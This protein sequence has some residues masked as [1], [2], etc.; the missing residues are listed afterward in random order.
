V[1]LDPFMRV[2]AH[3]PFQEAEPYAE[4]LGALL[5]SL[6]PSN[7]HAGRE[8][9]APVLVLPRVFEPEFCRTL[10][11][12]YEE[13]GGESSGFMR[14][15]EGKTIGILD[16]KFKRR[17]DFVFD[18]QDEFEALREA[19]RA[20]VSRRLI[21]AIYK[22]FQFK[23]SR[24]E[25]FIVACYDAEAGGFFRPHRDNTTLGTAHRQFAVTI[26]LNADEFEGGE[27][28]FPE[29]GPQSYRAPTGGAVVFSCGL[30]HEALPVT[31]GRRY[32][33]LPFL[34]N[35]EGAEIRRRNRHVLSGEIIDKN[36]PAQP[37]PVAGGANVS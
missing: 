26:N 16:D 20:R 23:V 4:A 25:R 12:L 33:C 5:A 19:V 6:P 21:P 9:P 1:V 18:S 11:D 14:E 7:L 13:R 34:Y 3:L 17:K 29:F 15:V 2:L 31:R 22:A 27:L 37:Q 28:R 10:I 36:A 32:A 8:T 24:I 30:L 35:E